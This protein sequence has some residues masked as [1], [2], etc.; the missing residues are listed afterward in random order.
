MELIDL[1]PLAV[2]FA[3]NGHQ[4]VTVADEP[5]SVETR[6]LTTAE[7]FELAQRAANSGDL[8]L[9]E[10]VLKALSTHPENEI[11]SEARFRLSANMQKRGRLSEGAVLLRAI[12]DE[13]PD[14]QRVRLELA[15][16]FE[17]MG[18]EAGARKALREVQAGGLPPD[19]A[20]LVDRYSAALRSRK[21]LGASFEISLAPDSNINRATRSDTLGTIIGDFEI[22]N[23]AKQQ[24]GIG[25]AVR[26]QFYARSPV[27]DNV[28]LVGRVNMG[29][30]LYRRSAFNDVSLA[31]AVGPEI[32]LGKDRL[33]ID[34]AVGRR[35]YGQVPFANH[36]Q[37]AAN[38][39]HPINTKTQL[40][41]TASAST[42]RNLRNSLQDG[43][44]FT[45]TGSVERALSNSMGVGLNISADRQD[46]RDPG[47]STTGGQA[48]IFGYREIGAT[49]L[50]ASL[51]H[52]RNYAD[53]RQLLFPEKR[54][55]KMFQASVGASFRELRFW[56]LAP[57]VRLSYERNQ[58]SVE[59]YQYRKL[60]AEFGFTR[61]F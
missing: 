30:N 56:S 53:A 10:R 48:S 43:N 39:L 31:L 6:I 15:R 14:A 17:L 7:M 40:R 13:E 36:I 34:F 24:S 5:R 42:I 4:P 58:S 25:F 19:V 18:D 26:G 33:A 35:W 55:D 16:V 49:T 20:R 54:R 23:D 47:Y 51:G 38:Y 3:A 59:I 61:A 28:N 8:E 1:V 22:D 27:S 46:L 44:A 41:I 29:G 37:L 12:L 50:F 2:L 21:P 60:R 11:R 9:E 57:L 45:L 52:S 32:A